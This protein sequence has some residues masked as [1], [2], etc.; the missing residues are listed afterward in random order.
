MGDPYEHIKGM[1]FWHTH[2]GDP[3]VGAVAEVL[4]Y[5]RERTQLTHLEFMECGIGPAGAWSG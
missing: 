1:R 5:G 3:A 2:V 4:K